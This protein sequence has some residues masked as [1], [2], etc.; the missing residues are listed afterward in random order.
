VVLADG[1]VDLEAFK[2]DPTTGWKQAAGVFWQIVDAIAQ[3]EKWTSFEV[4][5]PTY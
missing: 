1:G 4:S 2:F 5:L 3:A